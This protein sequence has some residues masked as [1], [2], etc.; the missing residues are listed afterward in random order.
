MKVINNPERCKDNSQVTT[1]SA[2]NSPIAK[3]EARVEGEKVKSWVSSVILA[4]AIASN[5]IFVLLYLDSQEKLEKAYTDIKTQ[6]WV[7]QDKDEE[8]FQKFVAGPYADLAGKVQA[9]LILFS[10]CKESK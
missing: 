7:K 10:K 5:V 1:T 2:P 6:V 3:A 4:L 8:K 9:S